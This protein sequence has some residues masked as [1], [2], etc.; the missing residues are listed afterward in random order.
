MA[1][2]RKILHLIS[3]AHLDPV[4]L[5]PERDGAAEALT[6][7]QSA[8]ERMRET[9]TMRFTRSSACTYRWAK[10]TDPRLF[11]EIKKRIKENRW[12]VI[13]GW[14]EQ[15]DCNIPSAESFLRQGLYG[16]GFFDSEF[17]PNGNTSIGYNPDSFGHAGGLPQ[18]LQHSGFDAYVFMRPEPWDNPEIPLLFWWESQDKSRV[19]AQ[20]IPNGYA[21]SYLATADD[22]EK[23]IR[24]AEEKNFAPGFD[25]GVFWFGIGNHGG[26]PTR[27]HIARILEL[28]NDP[29][30]PEIRFST[31]RDY[32][33]A[34]RRSPAIRKLPVI[35][36]ELGYTFRGCYSATGEVKQLHRASEKAL[37]AAEALSVLLSPFAS[38]CSTLKDAWWKLLFNEFHDVLAGTCVN[39]VQEETR[40]RF[41]SVLTDA[42]ET[43]RHASFS[44]ARRVDTRHEK[45][46][47]LFAANPLPW[48]R[49]AHVQIDTFVQ[50][51][52]RIELTHL[53]TEDGKQIPIQWMQA[54]ANYGPGG[55]KWGKLTAVLPL[56]AGGYRVFRLGG[57]PIETLLPDPFAVADETNP[58]FSKRTEENKAAV[59]TTTEPALSSLCLSKGKELL[60]SPVGTVVISDLG[61]TWGHGVKSYEDVLGHPERFS[62]EVLEQGPL[63]HI[64]REKSR[65]GRSEIWMD[66]LR[67]THTPAIEVRFRFN[68]QE[69]RKILKLSVS[70]TLK[71]CHS[72]A[73]MPAERVVRPANGEEFLCH[74]WVLLTGK[75][76]R[77]PATI[78]LVNNASYSYAARGGCL[79]MILARSAPYAEHPPFEYRDTRNVQFLD[80]GWQERRFLI[81]PCEGIPGHGEIDRLAQEFQ[82][83]AEIM[84]DSAHP[85]TEPWE[86]SVL[87]VEPAAVSLLASKA[88]ESGPGLIL[89]IQNTSDNKATA[90]IRVGA[91]KVSIPLN[92]NEIKTLLLMDQNG[93]LNARNVNAQEL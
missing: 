27:E 53:E 68:W 88:P 45:G 85:G 60:A 91:G 5:W 71:G 34:V 36:K 29:T 51:H 19:L 73:K 2:K 1:H 14:I 32:L 49:L 50:P 62:T 43:A 18:L 41:G 35:P 90:S 61:G 10:E 69:Q 65:W 75:R 70:T 55:L 30:L 26:G 33:D 84:L 58:Q 44:L 37:Q 56:P 22:V 46:S 93:H 39:T 42:R 6:T 74:D 11:K 13:G 31:V 38:D 86:K 7:M 17:G 20:R 52:G 24:S 54:D 23:L 40:L 67:F 48:K 76:G 83:P 66:I 12:E 81:L 63:V 82:I 9:S 80:Q 15:P 72:I 92:P 59:I 21:Q 57:R 3:Q 16:K 77:Q 8:I 89:R 25:H 87:S 64:T 28:Q 78:A 79:Q 47:V 4:W